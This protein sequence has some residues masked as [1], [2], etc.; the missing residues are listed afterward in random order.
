MI[1]KHC[2]GKPT[3]SDMLYYINPYTCMFYIDSFSDGIISK[4]N[5]LLT[6]YL[7][8]RVVNYQK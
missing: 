6:K 5:T 7:L 1:L 2:I 4:Y 8:H 3:K